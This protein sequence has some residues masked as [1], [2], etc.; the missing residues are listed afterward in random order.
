MQHPKFD[1]NSVWVYNTCIDSEKEIKMFA[2]TLQ[3]R[4]VIN[5]VYKMF[6]VKPGSTYSDKTSEIF[7]E[8]RSVVY[9]LPFAED[10]KNKEIIDTVKLKLKEQGYS[11]RVKVTGCSSFKN[12]LYLRVISEI[13]RV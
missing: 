9:V 2:N 3:V 1:N 12:G 7:P 10:I 6:N 8:K 5:S 13:P 11:N 4:S